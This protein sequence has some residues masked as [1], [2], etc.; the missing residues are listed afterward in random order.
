[1]SFAEFMRIYVMEFNQDDPSKNTAKKM[2]RKGFAEPIRHPRG[3]VLNPIVDRVISIADKSPIQELGITVIDSSWNKSDQHF[4]IKFM[5]NGR[6]LPFLL[7]GNP[8]N[9][10]KPLKLSSIEAVSASLY[11]IGERELAESLLSLFK[12]GRTFLDLNRDLLESYMGKSEDEIREI[13][14][15]IMD[16]IKGE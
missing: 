5:K 4:F 1:M 15:E 11:I 2:I 10:A 12:W 9:Y 13:E 7:A 6:R 8:V 14:R 16:Q 3:V